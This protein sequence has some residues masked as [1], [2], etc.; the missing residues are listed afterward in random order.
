MGF[1]LYDVKGKGAK[2]KMAKRRLDMI[3]GNVSSCSRC[4]NDSKRLKMIEE[5][6]QLAATVAEVTADMDAEKERKKKD[7][8][9]KVR[10]KKRKKQDDKAK[11]E[12]KKAAAMPS[13]QLL[14]DDFIKGVKQPAEFE[15]LTR[16]VLVNILKYFYNTRPIGLTKMSK[17]AVVQAVKQAHN[18]AAAVQ[19][20]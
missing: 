12:A 11:D 7:A 18:V 19:P 17:E 6:N 10:D 14:M 5:V 1:I 9:Q 4:L 20:I 3:T 8:A 2:T 15:S 16:P 13:I